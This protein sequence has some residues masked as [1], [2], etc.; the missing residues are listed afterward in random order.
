MPCPK[1]TPLQARFAASFAATLFLLFLYFVVSSPRL[2]YAIDVDSIT[3]RDHNHPISPRVDLSTEVVESDWRVDSIVDRDIAGRGQSSFLNRAPAGT[4]ALANNEPRLKNI[5]VGETQHWMVSNDAIRGPKSPSTPGLPKVVEAEPTEEEE[6][7]DR[8]TLNND[9]EKRDE[10]SS[11]A[12][13]VY[14]TANTC[15][16]PS[17]N[18]TQ[19]AKHSGAPQLKMY[20]SLSD[21]NKQPGP[22]T[23]GVIEIEFDDGYAY[24]EVKVEDKNN[25][26]IG[27]SAPKDP[28]YSGRYNYEI[29]ASIDAYYHDVE[30]KNPFLLFIDSDSEGA[31]LSTDNATQARPDEESYKDW[32]KLKPPWTMFAHPMNDSSIL[33]I[34]KSYCGLSKNALISKSGSNVHVGMTNRGLNRKPKQQFYVRNL[35]HSSNYYGILAMDGNSTKSGSKVVG[36][37]GKVWASMNFTTKSGKPFPKDMQQYLQSLTSL[38]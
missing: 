4:D 3:R 6:E 27:I 32:M 29:A 34:Q 17:L 33:G 2:A 23:S 15:L 16:Q 5:D 31:F 1:L 38:H 22:G 25:I 12:A 14:I 24:K 37:G 28:N 35:N 7:E 21:S 19:H 11:R 18:A 30:S 26:Y 9:E 10:G 20:I 36:G 13:T 8:L